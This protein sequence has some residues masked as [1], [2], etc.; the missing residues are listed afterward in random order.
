MT[1][2]EWDRIPIEP[3]SERIGR[4]AIHGAKLTLA[5][6]HLAQGAVVPLH[7]HE[8][9]QITVLLEGRLRFFFEGEERLAVPGQVMEVPGN[10]TH[11]VEALEDSLALDIFVPRRE[12]WM[13]G[14]DA[15][16]RR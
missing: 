8:S 15:Y 9:E 12:D 4:Q 2:H 7:R 16:L 1:L 11:G 14:E 6:I 13:R 3:L 5:R 10:V